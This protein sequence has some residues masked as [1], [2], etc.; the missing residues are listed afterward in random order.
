MV[1]RYYYG[2]LGREP[3]LSGF[4]FWSRA[5]TVQNES[6]TRIAARMIA[7]TEGKYG[8]LSNEQFVARMYN[9]IFVPGRVGDAKGVEYWTK[10]LNSGT[11]RT[12]VIELF[13]AQAKVPYA[14]AV[15]RMDQVLTNQQFVDRVYQY[16]LGKSPANDKAG[17]AY[18]T[19]RLDATDNTKLTRAQVAFE[20]GKSST[21]RSY[22]H[23][24]F[25]AYI[26]KNNIYVL[27]I[28]IK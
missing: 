8:T 3:D 17:H 28:P 7:S 19:K 9:N 18:W 12:R 24:R 1:F 10:K 6:P 26:E 2:L 20:I 25:K 11:K 14:T 27:I 13:A 16:M 15:Q 23:E 22:N 5:A 4:K 21:A